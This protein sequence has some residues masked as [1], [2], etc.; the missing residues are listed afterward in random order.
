MLINLGCG[1]RYARGWHNVDHAGSPHAKDET[2]DITGDLPWAPNSVLHV[3]MGHV[4]EHITLVQCRA[5]LTKLRPIVQPHGQIMVV[6][7]DI[8]IATQ[9]AR[10]GKLDVTLDSLKFGASRWPGDEHKW[11]CTAAKI[12][13]L[14]RDTR[15]VDV[16]N[17]GIENVAPFWPV[18]DRGPKWQ[19]AVTARSA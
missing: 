6:G 5:L 17:V 19:C 14:L 7:P 3:Y 12:V 9:L 11:E 8:T 2:L 18:A 1:D 4:L 10:E 16:E 15:W 13:K